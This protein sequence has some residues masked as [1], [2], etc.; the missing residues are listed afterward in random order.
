MLG[1]AILYHLAPTPGVKLSTLMGLQDHW[2]RARLSRLHSAHCGCTA[3]NTLAPCIP[4][5]GDATVGSIRGMVGGLDVPVNFLAWETQLRAHPTA[6]V[7]GVSLHGSMDSQ[8]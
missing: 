7:D 2:M 3:T 5:R 4:G 1:H 6:S 8:G